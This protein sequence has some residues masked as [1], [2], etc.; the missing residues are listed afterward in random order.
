MPF[1]TSIALFDGRPAGCRVCPPGSAHHPAATQG[2]ALV[3]Y[4]L[5]KRDIAFTR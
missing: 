1:S 2:R 3:L 4:L 5:P